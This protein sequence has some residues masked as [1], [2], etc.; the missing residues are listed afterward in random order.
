MIVGDPLR[1]A[2]ESQVTMAYASLGLRAL[3]FFRIHIAGVAHG[4]LAP[5]ATWMACSFDAVGKRV[6]NRGHHVYGGSVGMNA[7][8]LAQL[9]VDTGY[10]GTRP[11]DR[12]LDESLIQWAPNGDEAFDDRSYVLQLD[13]G[14]LVRVIGFTHTRFVVERLVEVQLESAEFYGILQEWHRRFEEEWR[15]AGKVV[16]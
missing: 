13:E 8:E 1:F 2:L 15:L 10:A 6:N 14:D 7:H 11:E 9:V 12:S 3:G 4:V 5:D 16:T